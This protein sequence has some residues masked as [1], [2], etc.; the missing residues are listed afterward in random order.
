MQISQPSWDELG[1]HPRLRWAWLNLKLP[2]NLKVRPLANGCWIL[3]GFHG[4]ELGRFTD[5]R[6]AK[7]AFVTL[8]MM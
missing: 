8:R 7:V 6:R 4:L 2:R 1:L 5:E 3:E